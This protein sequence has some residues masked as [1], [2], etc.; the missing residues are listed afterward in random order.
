MSPGR[1]RVPRWILALILV[2]VS[3]E[4]APTVRGQSTVTGRVFDAQTGS[5]LPSANI[6]VAGTNNG[7]ITNRDGEF[8]LFVT[9]ERPTLIVRFL[10]YTTREIEVDLASNERLE[11]PLTEDTIVMDELVVTDEDPA[12]NIMRRVIERKQQ[13]AEVVSSYRAEAYSRFMLYRRQGL[14]LMQESISEAYWRAD[15]GTRELVRAIRSRPSGSRDFRFAGLTGVPNL[16]DDDL[17]FHGTRFVGPTHPLALDVYT[18]RIGEN[19]TLDGKVVY[20]IYMTPRDP[21]RSTLVGRLAV[22]DEEYLILEADVRPTW[23]ALR[24]PPVMNWSVRMSQQFARFGDAWLPVDF[25]LEGSV[26]FGRFGVIYPE[27]TYSQVSRLSYHIPNAPAPDSLYMQSA[28]R[29]IDM[30]AREN[31]FLF[32]NNPGHVPLTEAERDALASMNPRLRLSNAFV[33]TGLLRQ[34][35]AVRVDSDPLGAPTIRSRVESATGALHSWYNRVDGLQIGLRP[36]FQLTRNL[37]ATVGAGYALARESIYHHLGLRYQLPAGLSLNLTDSRWSETT[38][39]SELGGLVFNSAATYLGEDDFYD[40]YL[41]KRRSAAL[42]FQSGSLSA[43]ARLTR[44]ESTSLEA[45]SDHDGWWRQNVQRVN[46][47]IDEGNTSSWS[48]EVGLGDPLPTS[49][50]IGISASFERGSS[51]LDADYDFTMTE[52]IV[53][54][55]FATMY[56]RRIQVPT[57]R[58]ALRGSYGTGNAPV[59]RFR[60]MDVSLTRRHSYGGFRSRWTLPYVADRQLTLAWEHDFATLPFEWMALARRVRRLPTVQVFASHGWASR[61][62]PYPGVQKSLDGPFHELGFSIANVGGFPLRFDWTWRLD[63]PGV[64]F[65]VRLY[66]GRR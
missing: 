66:R 17:A 25:R 48:V 63:Q 43:T 1:P 28:S 62:R 4:L 47:A 56:P 41:P 52:G 18:F 16:Y 21:L 12:Y 38:Y 51:L 33:P 2:I 50:G 65:W 29:Q 64:G 37:E 49:S 6:Q 27:A 5:P 3:S 53:G 46:P 11:I 36:T 14:V 20:E 26:K 23:Y 32:D 44:E 24:P 42:T 39:P 57:F 40:Y 34:Y 9:S 30:F 7:S 35:G 10:G 60:S 22:L 59:Q 55:A 31:E 19:T 15:G 58:A 54:A 61:S 8:S 45:A 13:M